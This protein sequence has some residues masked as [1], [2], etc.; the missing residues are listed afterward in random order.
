MEDIKNNG[1]AE[2]KA[3][4][5]A[6]KSSESKKPAV[7]SLG[8]LRIDCFKLFGITTSTFDGATHKLKGEYTVE[9]MR[10]IITDWQSKPVLSKKKEGK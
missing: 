2:V 8:R 7:F 6:S 5:P 9:D 10:K 3:E 1:A 4:T